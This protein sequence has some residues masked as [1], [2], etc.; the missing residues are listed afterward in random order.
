MSEKITNSAQ[1]LLIDCDDTLWENNIYF[2]RAFDEFIEFLGHS[3]L[4]PAEVR[5]VLDEIETINED[6]T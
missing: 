3:R 4:S 1:T 5:D 2:E 6:A